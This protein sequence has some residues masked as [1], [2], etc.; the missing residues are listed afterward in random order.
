MAINFPHNPNVN[1][2]HTEASLGRSWKWDGT[3]WLIYSSATTGI[4]FG[5][6][7]V[8]QQAASGTG[9]LTYNNAGVFTYTP[10]VVGSGGSSAFTGL[11]D[12]PGS[13]TA[14]K[15]LKV[16]AGGT[17]L[18]W[19]DAPASN[20]TN[21]Y[22]NTA[23]LSGNTLILT[24]TGTQ[25][26]LDVTVDLSSLNPVPTNITVADESADTECYPLFSK[27]ATG[28]IEPKTGSNIKFNSSSGQ[29][30]AGSFKK[31]GGTSSE[32]LK[33]DGS[34][35]STAYSTTGH[36]HSY[37]LND[38]TDVDTT[39]AANNKIIKHNGTSWVIADDSTGGGG[40]SNFTGLA[41]TPSSLTAG[42]WL[43]V[44]AGGTALEWTDAFSGSYND[45]SDKPT[46]PAAQVQ[47]DWNATTGLG[48][49]LN[50]PT[51]PAAY[52]N[53]DVDT[54]L[55]Q[56]NPTSGNVLSWNGS[57]YA[58]VAQSGGGGGGNVA[59]GTIAMWSGTVSSIP[60]GWQLCDGTNGSPD[61]RNKFVI[62]AA[63]DDGTNPLTGITGSGT[64]TG[65]S[66]DAVVVEH[67]HTTNIDGGHV[68][69]GNG[70]STYSYGGAG[71]YS[72]TVFNMDSE[73]VSGT[74]ANLPPY[75]ALC[76]I[77]CTTAGGTSAETDTLQTV[78]ARGATSDQVIELSG[79][80]GGTALHL[81]S[82]GDLRLWN[83][84]DSGNVELY[85]DDD[86]SL[87]I[88]GG[89][90]HLPG[91]LTTS[92]LI[93]GGTTATGVIFSVGDSGTSGD[94]LIQIKR[95]S[96]TTDCNIQ[97]VVA[98]T[99]AGTL[100][101]NDDGGTVTTGGSLQPSGGIIDKDGQLGNAG[102]V[103]SSTGSQLDWIDA[104]SGGATINNNGDNRLITG[105]ATTGEL[106]AES[107]LT[108]DGTKLNF[109]NNGKITF[110]N[111]L[112]ME[113][114]TDGS[115]NY[116]K[117]ATDGGGAFP[118]SIHSGS[119]EV[120]NIDDG[121]TQIKTGIKDKDGDL[122]TS[123]Q[124][125]S[126]TGTQVNWIDAPADNNTTYDMRTEAVTGGG[127]IRLENEIT[128]T[129]DDVQI[130]GGTNITVSRSA[131]HKLTINSDITNLNSLSDVTV[132][133]SPGDDSLIQYNSSSNQ[134]EVVA[135]NSV[136]S[137]SIP[138]GSVMLFY[139]TSAPTG[140]TKSTSHN[141][142][143]LR[144]VS[145]NGGGS[146]GSVGFT[147]AFANHTVSISGSDTVSIS[148]S[149]TVSISG[150]CGGSQSIYWNTTQAFLTVD[151]MPSHQHDYDVPR[152]TTGNSYGFQDTATGTSS[153]LQKVAAE[154]GSNYHTHAII[155]Q[156]VT[157][158]NFSFSGSDTVNISGSD[159]VNISGSDNVNAAVQY[160]DVIIC[161][162]N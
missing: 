69:P 154:G 126:S 124:I 109:S 138:S 133:G 113:V 51:I 30:E 122:G 43:K 16:N 63:D 23:S 29:L 90:G 125:L 123:G 143:A 129:T 101:L 82:G 14:G 4:A 115:V 67:E 94:K 44:N 131:D 148:D 95:A 99:G 79:G 5:D 107:S 86:N 103:L 10:P 161:S 136:G 2:V 50:K 92:G 151:Q 46:I 111:N 71:T 40:S 159:T 11:N 102:Q 37:A 24:R 55:N 145:G 128:N 62:G 81:K 49:L 114:Y 32:F 36:T 41:D 47:T 39:G 134:W 53:S 98:G 57:D 104:P 85:C 150:N 121:H 139:Q 68:I 149:D 130:L 119:D 108:Y 56:S 6:L 132:S 9:S 118:I 105:S 25:A 84:A 153:G 52:G 89:I 93:K 140:W 19:T 3:T 31:T 20:D 137:S 88:N 33:A 106:N 74:N 76:Y 160:L 1:D 87:K 96:T 120:I 27:D 116:I 28:N 157:G 80:S 70:G 18:E 147:S 64:S 17:A 152:G 142:K 60:T 117:S 156:Y 73:G 158:S 45:L 83:A 146:G 141:N 97:A 78:T 155:M 42:K 26:L 22:L 77:Y 38:L 75:Y 61:L 48:V 110:G 72:S 59:I 91:G 35:D 7:S 112:R 21:D 135:G 162:K 15:W 54:H 34:I 13:L 58:W 100:K 65:G 66:K 12:T 144:V 127:I 8:S